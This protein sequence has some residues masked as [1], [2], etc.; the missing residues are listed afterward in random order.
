[1]HHARLEWGDL[2][3]LYVL[4]EEGDHTSD[5]ASSSTNRQL[6][7][8]PMISWRF[9]HRLCLKPLLHFESA[10]DS[11]SPG[12]HCPAPACPIG[13][14]TVHLKFLEGKKVLDHDFLWTSTSPYMPSHHKGIP[15]VCWVSNMHLC[16][17]RSTHLEFDHKNQITDLPE[18][19]PHT[20][21]RE[22]SATKR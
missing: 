1:M 3:S 6:Q 11:E 22:W 21:P 19:S 9:V 17:G 5:D 13:C 10:Q 20:S 8:S 18:F 12:Y 7:R 14:G 4:V 2:Q 15:L 16:G